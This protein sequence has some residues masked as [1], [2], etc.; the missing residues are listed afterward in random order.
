MPSGEYAGFHS[1]KPSVFA[2]RR[3]APAF[4]FSER[5]MDQPEIEVDGRNDAASVRRVIDVAGE[6]FRGGHGG[7]WK[8]Q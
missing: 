6:A 2:V 4:V 5:Q 3:S 7:V 1:A 8:A